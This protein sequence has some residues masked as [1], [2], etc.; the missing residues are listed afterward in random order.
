MAASIFI[1]SDLDDATAKQL[2]HMALSPPLVSTTNT[3][4]NTRTRL[5]Q[6]NPESGF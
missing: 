2:T 1:D 6:F 4:Y 3:T 5:Q